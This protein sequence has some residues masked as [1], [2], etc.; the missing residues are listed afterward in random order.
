MFLLRV[1]FIFSM[2]AAYP[3]VILQVRLLFPVS[4]GVEYR[5][6]LYRVGLSWCHIDDATTSFTAVTSFN[7]AWDAQGASVFKILCLGWG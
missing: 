5:F 1:T 3:E 2:A 4:F 6:T 7:D